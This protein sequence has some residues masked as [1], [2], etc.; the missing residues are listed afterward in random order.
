MVNRI[1]KFI[2]IIIIVCISIACAYDLG[3]RRIVY[4]EKPMSV[5]ATQLALIALG[6]DVGPKGADNSWGDG[7]EKAYCNYKADEALGLME[8][9]K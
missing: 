6:Y 4:V 3:Q 1:C 5:Q 2:M 9:K 8:G 7:T